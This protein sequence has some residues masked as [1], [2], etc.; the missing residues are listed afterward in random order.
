MEL[1]QH[2]LRLILD[3]WNH[4]FHH[5]LE[6]LTLLLLIGLDLLSPLG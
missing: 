6:L 5:I 2:F 1:P 4:I 3:H